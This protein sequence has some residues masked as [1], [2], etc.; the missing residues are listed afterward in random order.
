MIWLLDGNVLIAVSDAEHLYHELASRW[1]RSTE[2]YATSPVV[3]GALVRHLVRMGALPSAIGDSLR[4]LTDSPNHEFWPDALPYA[5]AD[6]SQVIGHR[7]VTDAYLVS[8]VR[9][10]GPDARLAT[11]NGA[12]PQLY[13]DAAVLVA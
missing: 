1:L 10:H 6:L 9:Q 11:L 8:L 5:Q 12:L 2:R 4:R 3:Q 13:P 7:Q